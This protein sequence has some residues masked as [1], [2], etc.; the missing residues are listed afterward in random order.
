MTV[1]SPLPPPDS[2]L[3]PDPSPPRHYAAVQPATAPP[4]IASPSIIAVP[5]SIAV[6]ERIVAPELSPPQ[7]TR[8]PR[9]D[10]GTAAQLLPLAPVQSQPIADAPRSVADPRVIAQG[11][12]PL[13]ETPP[14][15]ETTPPPETPDPAI[16]EPDPLGELPLRPIAGPIATITV[17]GNQRLSD[18]FIRSR[19]TRGR[20]SPLN[21]TNIKAQLALLQLNP[22]FERVEGS[23]RPATPSTPSQLNV[24][25]VEAKP[26][27]G[28]ISFNNA[29]APSV[30]RDWVNLQLGSRNLTGNGDQLNGFYSRS[31]NGAANLAGLHY[32]IPLSPQDNTF[33]LRAIHYRQTVTQAANDIRGSS[34][35][36]EA[37]YRHPIRRTVQ[38]ELALSIDLT[39]QQGQTFVFNTLSNAVGIGPTAANG[40][41]T[42]V[43]KFGQEYIQ[44][45]ARG[46]SSLRSQLNFGTR[47]F[48]A[49]QNAGPIPDGQFFSWTAQAQRVQ[50]LGQRHWLIAQAELQLTPNALLPSQQFA[51]GGVQSVRGYRQSARSGDNGLR[52][53]LEGRI[54]LAQAKD[55]SPTV[56]IAPFIEGGSLWNHP[57]NPHRL[58]R[59]ASLVTAGLG[60]IFSPTSQI[61]ARLDYGIPLINLS[62]RGNSLQDNGLHFQLSYQR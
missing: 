58:P 19:I 62:H 39:V 17:E 38:E 26:L 49:T 1:I 48:S 16:A 55:Q 8:D 25:V 11:S 23:L 60:L 12:S 53:S 30:G 54:T 41:R 36:Y 29:I 40:S 5:E 34:E 9:G 57:D 61:Q 3:P 15:P 52:L 4:Q 43:L 27:T 33:A 46:R 20:P 13:P 22:L 2:T 7:S 51:L 59:P 50:R 37:S 18:R 47:L 42:S 21:R 44:R 31:L 32:Q 56:Q 28:S 10:H 35:F 24:R 14:L 6:T 45:D